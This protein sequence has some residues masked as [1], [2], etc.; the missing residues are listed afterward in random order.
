MKD[1]S[2]RH[3]P[4]LWLRYLGCQTKRRRSKKGLRA[5]Q[6]YYEALREEDSD[7][8]NVMMIHGGERSHPDMKTN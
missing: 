7:W 3:P 2:P 1:C 5:R 4:E 8:R 6:G